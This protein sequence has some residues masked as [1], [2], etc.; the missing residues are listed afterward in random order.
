MKNLLSRIFGLFSEQDEAT[1]VLPPKTQRGSITHIV[2][3]DGTLSRL[4]KGYET[5]AGLAYLLLKEATTK[6]TTSLYYEPGLQWKHW[7]GALRVMTG[8]GLADQIRRA[9]GTIAS[10]YRPGDR[11]IFLGYSRGA[12]AVRSLAGAIDLI[13]LL[14]AEHATERNIKQA[15]RLYRDGP[16]TKA[17]KAFAAAYCHEAAPIEMMGVWETVKS[18]GIV[19]PFFWRLSQPKYAFHN[20]QLGKSIANGFHALAID[21]RRVAFSPVL[22]RCPPDW[23]GHLEQVWFKGVHGDIGGHV[24]DFADARPLANIPLVW[25]LER[26]EMCGVDLP[27]NWRASYPQDVSAPSLGMNRSFGKFFWM[28]RRRIIGQDISEAKHASL[29][30][31]VLAPDKSQGLLHRFF[32]PQR[33]E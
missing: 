7:G 8:S 5:N 9:Y 1:V 21:E 24:D 26:L 11:I 18:L 20:D 27:E 29:D 31:T 12:F 25:M 28:R 30:I 19:L 6:N 16:N 33:R 32:R 22:W 23:Q 3:L 14:K 10:R 17:A 4:D 13:G 2:I 15:W